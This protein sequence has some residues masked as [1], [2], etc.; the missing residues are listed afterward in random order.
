[1]R[2]VG[3]RDQSSES[4]GTP[5]SQSSTVSVLVARTDRPAPRSTVRNRRMRWSSIQTVNSSWP[6]VAAPRGR[7]SS[8]PLL[9]GPAGRGRAL[10][11]AERVER[12]VAPEPMG[13]VLVA[14]AERLTGQAAEAAAV[15]QH[16]GIAAEVDQVAPGGGLDEARAEL[17]QELLARLGRRPVSGA[18]RPRTALA[19]RPASLPM[20]PRR[21]RRGMRYPGRG[22]D[23]CRLDLEPGARRRQRSA[24]A[25][26]DLGQRPGLG[27][28]SCRPSIGRRRRIGSAAA[29]AA[30]VGSRRRRIGLR[31]RAGSA[32]AWA[33]RRRGR[34]RRRCRA[35]R[36][37]PSAP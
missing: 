32:V 2:K 19:A 15:D 26:D 13:P 1:M 24:R 25:G 11:F 18:T 21:R 34:G 10:Q 36:W 16:L 23:R 35:R 29:D 31:L 33:R 4:T 22:R 7:S 27:M 28:R 12:V 9:A 14:G 8:A 37:R 5:K 6:A 3:S 30:V 20:G 17:V